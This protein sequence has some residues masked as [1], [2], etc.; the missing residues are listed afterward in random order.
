MVVMEKE[1][2]QKSSILQNSI[3]YIMLYNMRLQSTVGLDFQFLS[4]LIQTTSKYT[5]TSID[6]YKSSLSFPQ[7]INI[8]NKKL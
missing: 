2:N 8:Y 4:H 5:Y 7:F 1:S 6:G 3:F